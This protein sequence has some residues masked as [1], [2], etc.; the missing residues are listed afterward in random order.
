LDSITSE[1][2]DGI[3]KVSV[4]KFAQEKPDIKVIEIK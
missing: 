3:L 4:E 2:K 1:Y